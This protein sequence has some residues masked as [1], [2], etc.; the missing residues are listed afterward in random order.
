[1]ATQTEIK[2]FQQLK[3][4]AKLVREDVDA[5]IVPLMKE[6]AP[7]YVQDST[8]VEKWVQPVHDYGVGMDGEILAISDAG[9]WRGNFTWD[10]G[11]SDS[12]INAI[13]ALTARWVGMFARQQA[14]RIAASFVQ[15][16]AGDNTRR[17]GS[18][19]INLYGGDTELQEYLK[20]AAYQNS[21]LIQSIPSQYLEQVQNIVMTNMRNGMRPSYIEQQLVKQFGVTERRAKLIARDQHSKIQGDMTRIRQTNSGIEYFRWVTAHDERVRHSHVE[22]SKRDVGYGEGVFK[23]SDLPVVDGVPTFP[24]QPINCRCVARPVTAAAVERHKA[25]KG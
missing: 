23:W 1:M 3:Q 18:F 11:W 13:Q 17:N 5:N 19:A 21:R 20:A 8:Y 10:A 22:V 15:A 2:Y 25:K 7:E 14:E 9:H 4:M 24:G 6:L 16:A 12:I